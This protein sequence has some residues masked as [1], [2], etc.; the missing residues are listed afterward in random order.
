MSNPK[1]IGI[2]IG[3]IYRTFQKTEKTRE[4]WGTSYLFSYLCKKLLSGII[5]SGIDEK[6]ILLP[7]HNELS[8]IK[9][10]V[11]LYPDRII[12]KSGADDFDKVKNSIAKV[13]KDLTNEMYLA[14]RSYRAYDPYARLLQK[15]IVRSKRDAVEF[16][17]QYLQVYTVEASPL[18]LQLKDKDGNY[19]E[20]VKSMNVLMD[21]MEL[22]TSITGFDP[23]PIKVF[24]RG[25]NH[26]FL[27]ND[28]FGSEFNHF[29]S[30]PEIATEELR[31]ISPSIRTKYDEIIQSGYEKLVKEEAKKVEEERQKLEQNSNDETNE[32]LGEEDNLNTTADVIEEELLDKLFEIEGI[33]DERRTYHKYVAIVHADGDR[34]GSLIGSLPEDKISKFSE[35]LI[36]F[37]KAANI[38]LAGTRFTSGIN[39]TDWGYGAAPIFIG[40]DDL[41]F[42]APVASRDIQGNYKTVFHLIQELD[43]TFNGIFNASGKYPDIP[44]D[45]R[46]CLTYGVSI[47]YVKHPLNEAYKQSLELMQAVKNDKYPS[48]NRVNFKIQKHSGQWFGGIIDKNDDASWKAFL[49]LLDANNTS[50]PKTGDVDLF[51]NSLSQKLRFYQST[52][53]SRAIKD[54]AADL[55][56]AMDALFENALDEGVHKAVEPYLHAIR[57][58]LTSMLIHAKSASGLTSKERIGKAIDTLHGMLRFIHFIRDNE[59]RN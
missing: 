16:L 42:F 2:T 32:D 20:V 1:Y 50:A 44:S 28:A 48:R 5:A 53:E 9:P 13:K 6:N 52:I 58:L 27:L 49:A 36:E 14:I 41:V 34:M 47:S 35:D 46:P 33:E 37:A 21:H 10:G 31:F 57:N 59:F 29:P 19:L 38:V 54:S 45:L 7:N 8:A 18:D 3:P 12:L 39:P 51:I 17:N 25:I 24:L 56:T 26:S 23:D 30:L 11:G 4:I 43:G 22:R 15:E 55:K 40:G